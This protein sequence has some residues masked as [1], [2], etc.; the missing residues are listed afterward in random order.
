MV[1]DEQEL[2]S[3]QQDEEEDSSAGVAVSNDDNNNSN[4]NFGGPDM[5]PETDVDAID[6]EFQL[7]AAIGGKEK[8]Q[9]EFKETEDV[10][11]AM[12]NLGDAM[13]G[14]LENKIFDQLSLQN[15]DLMMGSNPFAPEEDIVNYN[16]YAIDNKTMPLRDIAE[17][18][19]KFEKQTEFSGFEEEAVV[20]DEVPMSANEEIDMQQQQPQAGESNFNGKLLF[21]ADF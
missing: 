2:A 3:P 14:T 10:A 19:E 8:L 12:N 17:E 18:L 13:F 15:P 11:D 1:G 4:N 7:N 5:G 16:D 21:N 9:M 20:G 6:E